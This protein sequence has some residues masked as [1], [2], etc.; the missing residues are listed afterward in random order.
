MLKPSTS[1]SSTHF[2]IWSATCCGVPTAVAPR[3]PTVMCSPTV[4]FVHLGTSGVALDQPSTADLYLLSDCAQG[5]GARGTYRIALLSTVRNSS[6]SPYVSRSIP[7]HPP[8]SASAPSIDPKL[9]KYANFSFASSSVFPRIGH[10]SAKNLIL[11]GS[12]PNCVFAI[13]RISAIFFFTTDGL[14]PPTKIASAC[15]AA[16]VLPA[17]DVPACRIR[18]VRWGDGWQR[19]GPG[20]S[21]YLPWW[22]IWRMR[23]GSA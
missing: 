16:N 10:N 18:G 12:L 3:P 21:K 6:S 2:S 23:E 4:F 8:N 9:L 11:C 5:N 20:T 1:A 15:C 13:S 19:C 14:C 17:F 7:V 22:L